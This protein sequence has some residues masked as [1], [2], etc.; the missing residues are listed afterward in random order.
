MSAKSLVPYR[1]RSEPF[2]LLI[3]WIAIESPSNRKLL[4]I[5]FCPDRPPH[6]RSP[7]YRVKGRATIGASTGGVL[8]T[9]RL[10][11]LILLDSA[12]VLAFVQHF[13]EDQSFVPLMIGFLPLL[14]CN[15][16]Y[17]NEAVLASRKLGGIKPEVNE[18]RRRRQNAVPLLIMPV[19]YCVMLPSVIKFYASLGWSPAVCIGFSVLMCVALISGYSG[20]KLLLNR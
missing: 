17:F 13:R 19:L 6:A 1:Q 20:V 14:L 5:G 8:T 15:V 3:F 18:L 12:A 7:D 11:I 2:V 10:L 9:R 4:K 16:I